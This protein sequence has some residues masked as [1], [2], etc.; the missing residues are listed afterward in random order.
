MEISQELKKRF[1]DFV[2]N[3]NEKDKVALITHTDLDGIAS[4][5]VVGKV[6]NLD[7]MEF[8]NYTDF[9]GAFVGKLKKQK[10]TK[11]IFTDFNIIDAGLVKQMEGFADVMIIDH[12]IIREDFNSDK[13]LFINAQGF[14]AAEIAYHLF[15]EI[16]DISEVDWLIACACVAD[17]QYFNNKEFMEKVYEKYDEHFDSS[18]SGIKRS[19]FWAAQMIISK[20]LIYFDGKLNEA[21]DLIPDVFDDV[22]ELKQYSEIIDKEID[23]CME[24]FEKEK[25]VYGDLYFWE[26]DPKYKIKSLLTTILSRKERDKTFLLVSPRDDKMT[27][28]ARRQDGKVDIP[29]LL[30]E[31]VSGLENSGCGGHAQA[32]G[33]YFMKKDLKE[34]RKRAEKL[35]F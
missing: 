31:L 32:A 12:H 26:F 7:L 14:C 28:S 30:G 13:T 3:V 9:D 6:L 25:K 24:E 4:A 22:I 17:F 5:K 8:M 15:S 34:F 23:K 20:A 29:K 18:S 27:I 33:G 19:D 10:F 1:I 2:N 21:Y 35:E 11:L 16:R